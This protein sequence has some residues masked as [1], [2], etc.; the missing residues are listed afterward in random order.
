MDQEDPHL[1]TANSYDLRHSRSVPAILRHV[2]QGFLPKKTSNNSILQPRQIQI[3]ETEFLNNITTEDNSSSVDS[4]LLVVFDQVTSYFTTSL[5]GA[6]VTNKS[7][8]TFL[9]DLEGGGGLCFHTLLE[10]SEK[11][12]INNNGA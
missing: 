3:E 5:T 2:A 4:L 10:E 11:K 12:A 8:V 9:M 7:D 1:L 6:P